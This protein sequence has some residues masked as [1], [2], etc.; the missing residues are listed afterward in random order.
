V[1]AVLQHGLAG[2]LGIRERRRVDMDHDLIAMARCTGIDTVVQRCLGQQSQGV[3]LLLLQRAFP[4]KR[5]SG[6]RRRGSYPFVD[7]AP[8]AQR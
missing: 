2:R 6:R 7:T 8:G 3:G 4:R 1:L 5:R